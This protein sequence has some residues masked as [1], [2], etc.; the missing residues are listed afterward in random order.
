MDIAIAAHGYTSSSTYHCC[1]Q[2][3]IGVR[4]G[5]ELHPSLI[6][7]DEADHGSADPLDDKVRSLGHR[8]SKGV[9]DH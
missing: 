8:G 5:P 9:L 6:S 7:S 1:A 3:D 2:T 4:Q